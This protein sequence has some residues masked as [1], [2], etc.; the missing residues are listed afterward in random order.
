MSPK[1]S[2]PVMPA[3]P[4]ASGRISLSPYVNEQFPNW[5]ELLSAR[6]VARLTRRPRWIVLTLSAL[7]RFPRKH[8][9]HGRGIGW[10]RSDVL[11]WMSRDVTIDP[12]PVFKRPARRCAK[13]SQRQSCLPFECSSSYP[14]AY[15]Q[16]E[17]RRSLGAGR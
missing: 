17:R 16:N 7:S 6:D 4:A 12:A 5:G 15:A 1:E 11:E 2:S 3:S 8:R 14:P 10:L 13:A 9:F